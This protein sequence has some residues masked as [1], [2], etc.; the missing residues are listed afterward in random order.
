MEFS[1]SLGAF[2]ATLL[3]EIEPTARLLDFIKAPADHYTLRV[4]IPGQISKT[5]ILA[6]PLI[7]DALSRPAAHR[8][9]RLILRSEV[10]Q[11]RSRPT[12]SGARE[13][14]TGEAIRP[15]DE[16]SLRAMHLSPPGWRRGCYARGARSDRCD[17]SIFFADLSLGTAAA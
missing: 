8:S 14:P 13:Q 3:R 2:V 17:R 1:R 4:E 9:L 7:E 15:V 16:P 12:I 5:V 11:Q 6:R 10:L